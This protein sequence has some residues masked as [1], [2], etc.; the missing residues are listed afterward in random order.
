MLR[1][2]LAADMA[3]VRTMLEEYRAALN[4]DLAFQDF[5]REL[6]ALPYG[7]D[8]IL[9]AFNEEEAAGCV[10]LRRLDD[11]VCEM[12]RL[13]VRRTFRG[14]A[15]GRAL[16]VAV[17]AEASQRG[18]RRMRLDTLPTMEEAMALYESLGFKEIAPYRFNPVPATR[19]LE[20]ALS[21]G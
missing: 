8:P 20:L 6:S 3:L 7:Y 2:E 16:A 15:I 5:D 12:K 4:V 19:Y 17:I 21:A 9:V 10:A 18:F 14:Q 11:R 13:Y 1:I